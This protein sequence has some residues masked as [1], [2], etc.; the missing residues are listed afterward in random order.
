M[1]RVFERGDDLLIGRLF[2]SRLYGRHL[3]PSD[4]WVSMTVMCNLLFSRGPLGLPHFQR[5]DCSTATLL[6][7]EQ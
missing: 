1:E 6:L 5:L 2:L 4:Q 7:D 3:N